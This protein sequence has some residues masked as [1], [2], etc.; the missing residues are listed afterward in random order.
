[1][2]TDPAAA[3]LSAAL[4]A[5]YDRIVAKDTGH[6][7]AVERWTRVKTG[8]KWVGIISLALSVAAILLLLAIWPEGALALFFV[9]TPFLPGACLIS[10]L[11]FLYAEYALVSRRENMESR[12][13]TVYGITIDT[14]AIPHRF[15]TALPAAEV[16]PDLAETRA[17]LAISGA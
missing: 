15:S 4:K 7:T 8:S 13:A 17:Y 14:S 9:A 16:H 12:M 2:T 3:E 11:V 5:D 6:T 10:L 1:M